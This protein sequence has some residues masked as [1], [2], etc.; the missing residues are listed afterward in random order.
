[1]PVSKNQ[2]TTLNDIVDTLK[3][4]FYPN[5][6]TTLKEIETFNNKLDDFVLIKSQAME[7]KNH[8]SQKRFVKSKIGDVSFKVMAVAQSSFNVVLQNADVSISLL[9][10]SP[11][12]KIGRASCRERVSSPV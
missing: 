9:K 7:I 8:D 11:V 10:I 5:E 12:H 3:L 2:I 1:M 4:Q 6:N